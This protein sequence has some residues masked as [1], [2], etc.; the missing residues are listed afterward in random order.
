MA[1]TQEA[2]LWNDAISDNSP[3]SPLPF[4]PTSLHNLPDLLGH[5]RD[6]ALVPQ[7]DRLLLHFF[8]CV[9]RSNRLQIWIIIFTVFS[10]ME[11]I[12][13]PRLFCSPA[14]RVFH[15]RVSWRLLVCAAVLSK[16]TGLARVPRSR[17]TPRCCRHLLKVYDLK[18]IFFL[19]HGKSIHFSA[20]WFSGFCG[21]SSEKS[22]QNKR[23][24][25]EC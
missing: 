14:E 10:L 21:L 24:F 2:T 8:G 25:P 13:T 11:I 3:S 12:E 18:K 23:N 9:C 16:W 22:D 17:S 15:M 19:F 7:F 6:A 5:L 20:S 4:S 1:S